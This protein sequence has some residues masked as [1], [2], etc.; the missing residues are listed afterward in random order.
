MAK[1]TAK[2]LPDPDAPLVIKQVRTT[3]MA[4]VARLYGRCTVHGHTYIYHRKTD[5]LVRH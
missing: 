3:R 1:K 5:T 2:T 4:S